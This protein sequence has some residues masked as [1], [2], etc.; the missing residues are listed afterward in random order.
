M[1]T[2]RKPCFCSAAQSHIK[3]ST[4]KHKVRRWFAR[5]L[6]APAAA[7]VFSVLSL[8]PSKS[9][10]SMSTPAHRVSNPAAAEAQAPQ[11]VIPQTPAFSYDGGTLTLEN[12]PRGL[13]LVYRK[14]GQ[15]P[16]SVR[17][18]SGYPD[19]IGIIT[20]IH[21]GIGH[22]V[23]MAERKT[24]AGTME[25][26]AVVTLGAQDVAAGRTKFQGNELLNS[27]AIVLPERPLGSSFTESALFVFAGGGIV[28]YV[29]LDYNDARICTL[30]GL[31]GT[32]A[33]STVIEYRG[34]YFIMQPGAVPLYV[35]KRDGDDFNSVP[36][37]YPLG[38]NFT[39][40]LDIETTDSG[41]SIFFVY[42]QGEEIRQVRMDVAVP[43]GGDLHSVGV[44]VYRQAQ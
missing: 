16:K 40:I 39:R 34:L 30:S 42:E 14:D 4:P 20:S 41:F 36:W 27:Y 24:E 11:F 8:F 28:E 13:S 17:I 35:T 18:D 21:Y 19:V 2:A 23:L 33:E 29:P 6:L 32:G 5:K 38:V 31:D 25:Y 7:A 10:A 22:S 15:E 3:T 12:S 43:E 44:S 26:Y 9:N 1:E 37:D